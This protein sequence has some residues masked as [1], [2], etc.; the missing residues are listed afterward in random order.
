MV[1]APQHVHPET[2]AVLLHHMGLGHAAC[3]QPGV[4]LAFVA[5]L[6][7]PGQRFAGRKLLPA[8][9]QGF[10]HGGQGFFRDGLEAGQQPHGWVGVE[11]PVFAAGVQAATAMKDA[12]GI[13]RQVH[14]GDG[15]EQGLHGVKAVGQSAGRYRYKYNSC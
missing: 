9:R 6:V 10:A 5:A 2:C 12:L 15:V 3:H 1:L 8:G 14:R 11:C 13:G 7:H 4:G